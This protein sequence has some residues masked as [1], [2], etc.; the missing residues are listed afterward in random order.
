MADYDEDLDLTNA[1]E[2]MTK[3]DK[4][5]GL[6]DYDRNEM[7][8]KFSLGHLSVRGPGVRALGKTKGKGK[9]GVSGIKGVYYVNAKRKEHRSSFFYSKWLHGGK[10]KNYYVYVKDLM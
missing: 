7:E 8:G 9:P 3:W 4:E 1:K 2:R 6:G 5:F 10:Q